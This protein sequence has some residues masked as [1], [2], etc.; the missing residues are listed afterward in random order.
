[1]PYDYY[2]FLK[3]QT[4]NENYEETTDIVRKKLWGESF[5]FK[6]SITW[7]KIEDIIRNGL[8]LYLRYN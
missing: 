2:E 4:D 8:Y 5:N 6:L 3:K 1:M 7:L